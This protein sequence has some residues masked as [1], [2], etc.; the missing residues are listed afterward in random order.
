MKT[1]EDVYREE[2]N[3]LYIRGYSSETIAL[4][5]GVSKKY[6]MDCVKANEKNKKNGSNL[7]TNCV[8]LSLEKY[9][10]LKNKIEQQEVDISYLESEIK[11]LTDVITKL[12]I[13][14]KI[15]DLVGVDIPLSCYWQ[16]DLPSDKRKYRI[17]F[18]VY[19]R[20]LMEE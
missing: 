13:P 1:I 3:N 10:E 14:D 15:I 18:E 4:C 11:R 6:V 2:I 19:A 8:N 5:M 9:E 7:D 17:E 16:D 20:D 12:G